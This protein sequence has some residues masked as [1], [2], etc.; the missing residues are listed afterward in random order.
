M[1]YSLGIY[2]KL[3]QQH[4]PQLWNPDFFEKRDILNGDQHNAQ[5]YT[6]K[7][8][9]RFSNDQVTPGFDIPTRSN[10]SDAPFWPKDLNTKQI[11]FQHANRLN[12]GP[13]V[14]TLTAD[15]YESREL[16]IVAT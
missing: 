1:L 10:G 3:L 8:V 13:F 11:I 9:V 14:F 5:L 16:Y 4:S 2:T 12:A 15:E 6:I 7:P